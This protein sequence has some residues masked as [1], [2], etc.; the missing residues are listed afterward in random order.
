MIRRGFTLIELLVVLSILSMMAGVVLPS[1]SVLMRKN[2]LE[3]LVHHASVLCREAFEQSVFS[4]KKY[5]IELENK[6][7]LVVYY[8]Q[9][10]SWMPAT[11]LWLRPI[12]L[13]AKCSIDWPEKGWQIL[14]EG[15]CESPEIRFQDLTSLQ[16]IF[17]RIRAYD[18]R[19]V[20]RQ[21][22]SATQ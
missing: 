18:A 9:N 12:E 20:R 6:N 15:Y 21:N 16:T 22:T 14:P 1:A 10:S 19:L 2:R 4:G 5:K 11:D 7:R 13:P 8:Y 3:T 17:V